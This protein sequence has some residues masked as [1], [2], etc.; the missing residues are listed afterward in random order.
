MK[1]RMEVLRYSLGNPEE[2]RNSF[3]AITKYAPLPSIT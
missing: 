1:A 3:S 2:S